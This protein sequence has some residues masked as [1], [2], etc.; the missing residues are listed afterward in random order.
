MRRRD[1]FG[2]RAADARDDDTGRT[3]CR[4]ILMHA[5]GKILGMVD[6][7]GALANR[8]QAAMTAARTADDAG[9][10]P[11][12]GHAVSSWPPVPRDHARWSARKPRPP[13]RKRWATSRREAEKL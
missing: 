3:G 7:T 13:H 4:A 12:C 10:P 11:A 1:N 5:Q 2:T 9:H 8:L 6:I